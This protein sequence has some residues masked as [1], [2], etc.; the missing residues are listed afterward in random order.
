MLDVKVD[1]LWRALVSSGDVRD[2]V[3][4]A[5][6]MAGITTVEKLLLLDVHQARELSGLEESE[7]R[8]AREKAA[9]VWAAPPEPLTLSTFHLDASGDE[10]IW[11]STGR[12][13]I[14]NILGG[15]F[16]R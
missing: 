10:D 13:E 12:E 9:A 3:V 8:Y 6:V 15:G 16:P 5:L 4:E 1:Y 2:D 14:D 7:I 11:L